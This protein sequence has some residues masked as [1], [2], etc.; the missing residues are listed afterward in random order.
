MGGAP[1]DVRQ[2]DLKLWQRCPLMYRY[3]NIDHLPRE[4]SGSLSFGSIIHLC[5]LH[6]EV[7]QD[8]AAA[9]AMFRKFWAEPSS[10]DAEFKVDF[11]VRGTNWKKYLAEGERILR[12]WWS[13]IQWESD[14]VLGREFGFSV[15]I[16]DGHTLNGTID[17]LAIRFIPSI[18]SRV[19]LVSDYKDLALDTKLPTPTGWTTMA[20]VNVGDQL[21]GGDGSPCTVTAKSSVYTAND[22]YRI[23]FDDQSTITAGEHHNW[24][25]ET[26]HGD[27]ILTTVQM[28]DNLVDPITEQRQLRIPPDH[29]IQRVQS[30]T[31]PTGEPDR[32]HLAHRRQRVVL[33]LG[34]DH[35]GGAAEEH[36]TP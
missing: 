23:T 28:R 35:P 8:L 29:R 33:A 21:I 11:Y 10:V 32:L 36:L 13:L 15:P 1:I 5:V 19:V 22:C 12:H 9:I 27:K 25:V 16:G 14:V 2:S 4:Q 3:Q 6:L 31:A 18:N 17:K 26:N 20:E 30:K 24:A 34:V 7:E